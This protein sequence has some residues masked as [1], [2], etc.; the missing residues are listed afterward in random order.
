MYS[1]HSNIMLKRLTN[2]KNNN[3]ILEPDRS[4]GKAGATYTRSVRK[5]KTHRTIGQ[6]SVTRPLDGIKWEKRAPK[7]G[8]M[9]REEKVIPK[10]RESI[11]NYRPKIIAWYGAFRLP[12]AKGFMGYRTEPREQVGHYIRNR[13]PNIVNVL[14]RFVLCPATGSYDLF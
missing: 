6:S 14:K 10:D 2:K 3:P 11:L 12:T 1:E 8:K 5:E 9:E 7:K 13:F 4:G